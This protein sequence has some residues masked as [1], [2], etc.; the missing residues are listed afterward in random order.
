VEF[1]ASDDSRNFPP[2]PARNP[3]ARQAAAPAFFR[4][5]ALRLPAADIAANF[6]TPYFFRPAAA[7]T[8]RGLTTP[9]RLDTSATQR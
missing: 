3:L 1:Q 4:F 2:T 9:R 6:L 5:A 8:P 7:H